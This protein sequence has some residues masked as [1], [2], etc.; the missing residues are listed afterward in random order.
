M[1][2]LKFRRSSALLHPSVI[3]L[4]TWST[5]AG[6]YSLHLSG[7]LLYGTRD[8][9]GAF[10]F[11]VFP[12]IVTSLA[13]RLFQPPRQV[14]GTEYAVCP[15]LPVSVFEWRLRQG[16]RFWIAA[17]IVE[18]IVSGGVPIVWIIIGNGKSN[19]DYGIPS[20]HGLVN[21]LMMS[22]AVVYWAL[23]LYTGCRRHIRFPIFALAW[24]FVVVSRGTLLVLLLECAI[25]FLRLMPIKTGT[26]IRLGAV[27]L[28]AMMLF[29]FVGDFRNGADAFTALAQPTENFPRWAPPVLLWPYIYFTTPLNN[30][31]VTQRTRRPSFN[32]LL[33]NTVAPLFPSVFRNQIYGK[34]A[35]E[36]VS[37]ELL[38][39][40]LTASTAYVGPFQDMGYLGI[41]GFSVIAGLLCEIYWHRN[42]FWSIFAFALFTHALIMS[43]F[44]DLLFSAVLV[45]QFCCF[46]YLCRPQKK[47][48]PV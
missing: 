30:L 43:L 36:G 47:Q 40:E 18:I 28:S 6:L 35:T 29:G 3:A 32:V 48:L 25:V 21:A 19:F 46:Y 2:L 22:L 11:I 41:I 20:V 45:G 37:G 33:P 14:G 5:V 44:A 27:A 38:T 31:L 7:L 1:P 39:E 26:W 15:E 16:V 24:T 8:V 12:I 10:S 9:F 23:Y 13:Y 34:K 42:G 17:T 4:L